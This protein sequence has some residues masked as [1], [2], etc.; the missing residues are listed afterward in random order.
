MVGDSQRVTVPPI[1]EL[2]LAFRNGRALDG[3]VLRAFR[4]VALG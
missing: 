2:E 4:T 1:A 3:S